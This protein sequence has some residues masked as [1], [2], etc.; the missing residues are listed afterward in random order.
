[1]TVYVAK[2]PEGAEWAIPVDKQVYERL[3]DLDARS[4]P[5]GGGSRLPWRR[6][7]RPFEVELLRHQG[8]RSFAESDCPWFTADTLVCREP[9]RRAFE[10]LLGDDAEFLPLACRDAELWLLRVWRSLDALDLERSEVVRFP[11]SERL[12]KIVRHE[13][14]PEKLTGHSFFRLTTMPRGAVF[15]Q[16]AVAEAAAAAR[17]RNVA[18]EAV[19]GSPVA[20]ATAEPWS[21][22]N[23]PPAVSLSDIAATPDEMLWQLIFLCQVS[24]VKGSAEEQYRT[25]RSWSPGLRMLWATQLVDD[26]VSNGGFNQYFFNTGGH[27]VDEAIAGFKLIGAP[28]RAELVAA[29]AEQLLRDAPQLRPFYEKGTLEAFMESYRH[30]DLSTLDAAWHSATEFSSRRTRYIRSHPEEF[31][32]PPL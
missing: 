9:A 11:G 14:R 31:L 19:W 8:G 29:A 21:A 23:P 2:P 25:V 28:E 1:M 30:T 12:M 10:P 3:H 26:E 13:F 7:W 4:G 24:R 15:V 18:F 20:P 17:L 22:K 32:L 27:F 5:I 6:S 16:D